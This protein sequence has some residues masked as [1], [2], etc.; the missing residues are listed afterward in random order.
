MFETSNL[1]VMEIYFAFSSAI[2]LHHIVTFSQSITQNVCKKSAC[3]DRKSVYTEKDLKLPVGRSR[4]TNK[5]LENRGQTR[6]RNV[7]LADLLLGM[8]FSQPKFIFKM[9][10]ISIARVRIPLMLS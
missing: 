10:A 7:G 5:G 2:C 9:L 1:N 4:L 8:S 6:R 3:H